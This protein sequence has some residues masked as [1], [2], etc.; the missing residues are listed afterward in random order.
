M[1][2]Y[3]VL[4]IF[5]D[6]QFHPL[7]KDNHLSLLYVKELNHESQILTFD[8]LDSLSTDN[9]DFLENSIILTPNKKHLLSIHS[10]KTVYDIDLLNYYLF[11]KPLNFEDIRI[12]AIDT[13]S[14]RYYDMNNLNTII[15]IYKHLEYCDE[16]ANRILEVWDR[17]DEV[18]WN[19]YE[20]Y[21]N[22][23]ILAFYSI[24]KEGVD[25]SNDVVD[26]F[27]KRVE[28][29]LS[30][31]KLFTDYFL[32][33]TAGRP[34]NSFGSINFAA[35]TESKRRAIVPKN[36]MLFEFDYDA[37]HLR[38]I[39]D[40]VDYQFPEGPA[41]E[42][43]AKFYGS[44]DYEESK[45]KSF[46]YLYGGIP[47][48]V[49]QMN[50]FFSN[51]D[52]LS[53]I[54]WKQFKQ[55]KY[56]ETPIYKRRMMACNLQDMNRNKLLNYL[57]QATETERNIKTIIQVQR[58]L[59]KKKTSLILYN[60]DSFLFDYCKED[61]LKLLK[62][63]MKILERNNFLTKIKMGMDFGQMVVLEREKLL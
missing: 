13:I 38:L 22:E 14:S 51:V 5:I 8:H 35:L 19:S 21:N 40:I 6:N 37:Y 16:I 42:H 48:D 59:Y 58:Y 33:T 55:Q 39:A 56:I 25:V 29:H 24:E 10:F 30:D 43:L 1:N 12:N 3:I 15:P 46:Q 54:L 31:N 32:Y 23:A 11:N 28:K 49:V 34:S 2:S 62:G 52:D 63:I 47:P 7:H 9:F 20:Q 27:D 36:D 61:G 4:P 44:E 53:H 60:Y 50:P 17:K 41:H 26:I 57:I 18:D 45:A